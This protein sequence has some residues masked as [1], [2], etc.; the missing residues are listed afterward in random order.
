MRRPL[1]VLAVLA[2][3]AGCQNYRFENVPAQPVAIVNDY[4]AL[5]GV[6]QPPDIMIVQDTSGSMCESIGLT[7]SAGNSCISGDGGIG[8][9]P[10]YCSF[11]QPGDTSPVANAADCTFGGATEPACATKMQLTSYAVNASLSGLTLAPEQAYLGLMAFPAANSSCGAGTAIVAVGDAVPDTKGAPGTIQ[12]IQSFYS[13]IADSPG[14][15]T[16]TAATL[17]AVV[18]D[19]RMSSTDT[20]KY[21]LLITDGLP[22]CNAEQ[23]CATE[24]WSDGTAH[25]CASPTLLAAQGTNASPPAGCSCSFGDCAGT[26]DFTCCPINTGPTPPGEYCLDGQGSVAAAQGLLQNNNI[27]TIVVGMGLD[28]TAAQFSVLDDIMDAGGSG[29]NGGQHYQA[30]TP[31]E[32]LA[33]L[34]QLIQQLTANTCTYDLDQPPVDPG[35]ITV[36]FNGQLVPNDPKQGW[37]FTAPNE[38]DLHGSLCAEITDGGVGGHLEITAVAQ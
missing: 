25:G 31:A 38:I 30:N 17:K 11:C 28:F 12:Q 9:D 3:L 35:L 15:G 2:A 23:A 18:S 34:Q 10:T 8:L 32:L 33:V 22:N 14:G 27:K 5:Q 29:L 26:S 7:D 20:N 13:S 6:Q 36:T 4:V 21:V 16:P 19:P 24:P 37:T 1:L